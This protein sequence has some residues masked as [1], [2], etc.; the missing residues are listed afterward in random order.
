MDI[1][2]ESFE[3]E[4]PE[5]LA[6][7]DLGEDFDDEQLDQPK[8]FVKEKKTTPSQS[9]KQPILH[10]SQI[11]EESYLDKFQDAEDN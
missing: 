1:D 11:D 7:E 6:E 2:G 8:G 5:Q 10:A 9:S 3:Q 4:D